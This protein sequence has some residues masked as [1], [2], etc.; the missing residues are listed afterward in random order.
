[1]SGSTRRIDAKGLPC[2]QPVV[3]AKKALEEGG[4]E[5]LEILVDNDAARENVARFAEHGGHS[6]EAVE[7]A[8]GVSTIRIRRSESVGA[9]SAA[10]QSEARPRDGGVETVF[11][12]RATIGSGNDELGALLMKGFVSTLLELPPLPDRIIFM[13]G[14]VALAVEGSP[15]L[16]QLS[17]LAERGIE[18]LS[19]GTCLDFYKIKDKL[20][21]G[22][23]T[24]MLE[25]SGF[26]MRGSVLSM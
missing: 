10:A 16:G 24:N 19:C 15:C 18:I 6:V 22:K 17:A 4:F 23:I 21:V 9:T 25:I 3:L 7:T 2:P 20:A 5:L 26:L 12:S 11:I 1:M 13:N 8:N 14:G